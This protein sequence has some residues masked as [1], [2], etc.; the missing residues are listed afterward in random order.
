MENIHIFY[1]KLSDELKNG[2]EIYVGQGD[3]EIWIKNN[4]NV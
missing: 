4:F 3:N 1:D 2:I